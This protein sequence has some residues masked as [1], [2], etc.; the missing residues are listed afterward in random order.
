MALSV[1]GCGIEGLSAEDVSAVE[2]LINDV[3][4]FV[5]DELD[6][7]DQESM[8]EEEYFCPECNARITTDMTACPNCGIG[9][10]FEEEDEE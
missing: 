3:V 1:E 4:E 8:E 6:A 7:E 9:L 10:S 2:A 5:E